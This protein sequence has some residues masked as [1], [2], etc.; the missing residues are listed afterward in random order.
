MVI[1]SAFESPLITVVIPTYN[2]GDWLLESIA[3]CLKQQAMSLEMIVVDNGSSDDAP[4]RV[5]ADSPRM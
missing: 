2:G 5:A 4:D 1:T 3:S